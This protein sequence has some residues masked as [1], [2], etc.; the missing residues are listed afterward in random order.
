M[1]RIHPANGYCETKLPMAKWPCQ[2]SRRRPR[3]VVISPPWLLT[4]RLAGFGGGEQERRR[5]S[6]RGWQHG[7]PRDLRWRDCS[8]IS[9]RIWAA[10]ESSE[11]GCGHGGEGGPPCSSRRLAS[12]SCWGRRRGGSCSRKISCSALA[13]GGT[14]WRDG[15]AEIVG[16]D[17]GATVLGH[18]EGAG[19][20]G[21]IVSLVMLITMARNGRTV[22]G[23]SGCLNG[24]GRDEP[25]RA[26]SE[27]STVTVQ[28]EREMEMLSQAAAQRT[29]RQR[30]SPHSQETARR[31]RWVERQQLSNR[32]R[33][34]LLLASCD[35]HFPGRGGPRLA[36]CGAPPRSRQVG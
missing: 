31:G 8:S 33:L 19:Q 2:S 35:L 30:N 1:L 22:G 36:S 34:L 11:R 21:V 20:M 12:N 4:G 15:P 24:G 32:T 5:W 18:L 23:W 29:T 26:W 13:G 10:A 3:A 25:W 16:G 17:H 28:R 27:G 9:V 6:S 14:T 7:L